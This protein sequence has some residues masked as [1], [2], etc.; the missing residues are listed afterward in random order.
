[1][2][3]DLVNDEQGAVVTG[4]ER[5]TVELRVHG[6]SGTPTEETLSDPHPIQVA[7]DTETRFMR[8]GLASTPVEPAIVVAESLAA[9]P[10]VERHHR[11][12]EAY[13][14]G[15]LTAGSATNALYMT[16]IPFLLVN[17]AY[18]T[19]PH[20]TCWQEKEGGRTT[21]IANTHLLIR[22]VHVVIKLFALA[23]SL[24]LLNAA[25]LIS[26]DLFAWQFGGYAQDDPKPAWYGRL[27]ASGPFAAPSRALVLGAVLC[28]A[29]TSFFSYFGRSRWDRT[30]AAPAAGQGQGMLG[31]FA[32]PQFWTK[33]D[34]GQGMRRL[35]VAA[36]R[37][38]LAST[39]AWVTILRGG[40][41]QPTTLL[42]VLG[43]LGLG[44]LGTVVVLVIVSEWWPGGRDV[45]HDEEQFTAFANLARWLSRFTLVV[46]GVV[47]V[48]VWFGPSAWASARRLQL[49]VLQGG[50]WT[51]GL[52]QLGLALLLG[53]LLVC[54]RIT[55]GGKGTLAVDVPGPAPD[56]P[57]AGGAA[58]PDRFASWPDPAPIG[59]DESDWSR[60]FRPALAGQVPLVLVMLSWELA[61]TL[62]AGLTILL[63]RVLGTPVTTAAIDRSGH[64][65]PGDWLVLPETYWGVSLLWAV[66]SAVLVLVGVI[67]WFVH[68]RPSWRQLIRD[69]QVLVDAQLDPAATD[70]PGGPATQARS[71][72]GANVAKARIRGR[73]LKR[74]AI[75]VFAGAAAYMALVVVVGLG[76]Q[77][78]ISAHPHWVSEQRARAAWLNSLLDLFT[79][80]VNG[81]VAWVGS[82][83]LVAVA[84]GLVMLG[85]SAYKSPDMRRRTGTFFDVAC[86]W[87]RAAHPFAAPC[88]GERAVPDLVERIESLLGLPP[89]D[90]DD[91][92]AP[93]DQRRVIL[94]G[95]SQGSLICL[96][97]VM[98]LYGRY[99]AKSL[100][101]LS[102][103]TYGSQL[104]WVF[105]RVF[106]SYVGYWEQAVTRSQVLDGRWRNMYRPTDPIG[107]RVLEPTVPVHWPAAD[108]LCSDPQ[109]YAWNT[110]QGTATIRMH[111]DYFQNV[112]YDRAA[113]ELVILMSGMPSSPIMRVPPP[114]T[115]SPLETD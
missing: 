105:P 41:K 5:I 8:S 78:F 28:F 4:S 16:L 32:H 94:A 20:A 70:G 102:L 95:H 68:G 92:A 38:V 29:V 108:I 59:D 84:G 60:G 12:L 77:W 104:Q 114:A 39:M 44:I 47:L 10:K 24:E 22:T 83:L 49:P 52:V 50:Q 2:S 97:V 42:Y 79:Q 111:G 35:H 55:R 51:V 91:E 61:A 53:V 1:V 21:V 65:R 33:R 13:H 113:G 6:V 27:L 112:G 110:T 109:S 67:F 69:E 56:L 103:M 75:R 107:D 101:R 80:D 19:V 23:L 86:F 37:A 34:A 48:V 88:Y 115:G 15:R 74:W 18:W 64:V 81:G 54:V 7:G 58:A 99:G 43:G 85:R 98:Q 30:M 71:K 93:E 31:P 87:P 106:P 3:D 100:R 89:S 46:L 62:T 76:Y 66:G 96:S 26:L 9:E 63:A 17:V 82:W 14:W 45:P 11:I 90:G 57:P 72:V 73:L 36:M 25:M 40:T